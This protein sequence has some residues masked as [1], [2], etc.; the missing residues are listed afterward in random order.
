MRCSR[1]S[2]RSTWSLRR[3]RSRSSM[4]LSIG[5][6]MP[7]S[8]SQGFRR[9]HSCF[10]APCSDASC[11]ASARCGPLRLSVP[12]LTS[13]CS[14]SANTAAAGLSRTCALQLLRRQAGAVGRLAVVSTQVLGDAA[15]IAL[16][17]ARREQQLLPAVGQGVVRHGGQ[18]GLPLGRRTGSTA[19]RTARVDAVAAIPARAWR[20]ALRPAW[21][22][23]SRPARPVAAR[24]AGGWRAGRRRCTTPPPSV[25]RADWSRRMK[26]SPCSAPIGRSRLSCTSALRPG[27]MAAPSS[28]ITRA[29]TSSAPRCR[30]T[31]V[32]CASGRLS[33]ASSLQRARRS[34]ASGRATLRP[35]PSRRAARRPCPRR[36]G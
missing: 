36:P 12:S 15:G 9:S 3:L 7:P 16:D 25:R 1:C 31:G 11:P 14:S 2:T 10:S 6:W 5:G 33:P 21:A 30:C 24:G 4:S 34:A 27:A 29:P 26:R 17:L 18:Q 23:P 8:S 20:P 35:P 32:Q 13:L 22:V 19:R 28:S